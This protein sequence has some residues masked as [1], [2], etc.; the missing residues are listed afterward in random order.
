MLMMC[1]FVYSIFPSLLNLIE[2]Y[3][4]A[5]WPYGL[6]HNRYPQESR[7]MISLRL[8]GLLPECCVSES[9]KNYFNTIIPVTLLLLL[10]SLLLLHLFNLYLLF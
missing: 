9:I 2:F 6:F 3:L 4:L 7:P 8:S 10:F 5:S 1:L